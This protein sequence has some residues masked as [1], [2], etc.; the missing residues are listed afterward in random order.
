MLRIPKP[1]VPAKWPV[2]NLR[3]QI[4]VHTAVWRALA[5]G[6]RLSLPNSQLCILREI[7]RSQTA[8]MVTFPASNSQSSQRRNF[9]TDVPDIHPVQSNIQR[10]NQ[11][12]VINCA[13]KFS[14]LA[15]MFVR[16]AAFNPEE[17]R[18][19]SYYCKCAE[20][21]FGRFVLMMKS[22]AF[23]FLQVRLLSLLLLAAHCCCGSRYPSPLRALSRSS[24]MALSRFPSMALSRSR[25]RRESSTFFLNQMPHQFTAMKVYLENKSL[26]QHS[27]GIS[28]LSHLNNTVASVIWFC[29]VFVH[30][31]MF[32]FQRFVNFGR[33][34]SWQ[35]VTAAGLSNRLAPTF[36]AAVSSPVVAQQAVPSV[37]LPSQLAISSSSSSMVQ[38]QQQ[39]R[40]VQAPRMLGE[41]QMGQFANLLEDDRFDQVLS[42]GVELPVRLHPEEELASRGWFSLSMLQMTLQWLWECEIQWNEEKKCKER[43]FAYIRPWLASV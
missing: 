28:K 42:N 30:Q 39:A 18:T 21:S 31:L 15:H 11:C 24:S 36:Q 17:R 32:Y 33:Q 35:Q 19:K 4:D 43:A 23:D 27:G 20:L 3:R 38:Q 5:F 8:I 41:L 34:Q 9:M 26:L 12:N 25:Q 37:R 1:T 22:L 6:N 14:P 10:T 7:S 2:M 40:L 16:T 13:F 29:T